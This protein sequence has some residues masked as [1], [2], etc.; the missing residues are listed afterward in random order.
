MKSLLIRTAAVT[1]LVTALVVSGVSYYVMPKLQANNQQDQFM[2]DPAYNGVTLQPAMY[3]PNAQ[4]VVYTQPR[5]RRVPMT[6]AANTSVQR[7]IYGEPIQK[8]RSTGKSVL[9]VAG[10]AG[11]GAGIGALAGGKKGAAIGA[12]SGGVAGLIYDRMTAN[13][14]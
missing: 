13:K 14:Q 3:R 2:A 12:I 7:D 4:R 9:I 8:K 5:V 10:S 11:A 1:S 6:Q